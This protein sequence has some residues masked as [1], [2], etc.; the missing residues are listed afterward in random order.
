MHRLGRIV[1]LGIL[2]ALVVWGSTTALP[3]LVD[4][5]EDDA[6]RADCEYTYLVFEVEE[7]TDGER[8]SAITYENLSADRQAAFDAY[9][10]TGDGAAE[11]DAAIWNRLYERPEP[12]HYVVFDGT[13]YRAKLILQ[14]CSSWE[15]YGNGTIP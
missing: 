5:S 4:A 6:F 14:Q 11:L 3:G 12:V 7:P 15:R 2:L 10:D 9:L 13:L 8:A 1:T